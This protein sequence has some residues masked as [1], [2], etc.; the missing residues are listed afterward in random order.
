MK[1]FFLTGIGTD[2]GK[3]ITAAILAQ[4]LKAEYWKPVQAGS[5]EFTDTMRVKSLVSEPDC[6]FHNEVY[7]LQ[8][9][10][11]PHAAAELEGIDIELSDFKPLHNHKTIIIEGAGGL[12]VPINYR[13]LIIDLIPMI[14][15]EVILVSRNYL[16]SINH[17]L[18]SA[19][20]LKQREIPVRGIIFNGA[21]NYYTEKVILDQTGYKPL[22]HIPELEDISRVSV[23][24]IAA[25]ID[26]ELFK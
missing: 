6:I 19:F 21:P 17:T 25:T 1:R 10:M 23:A 11:S 15:D 18:L 5:L 12:L 26:V 9:P 8:Q 22:A 2:V 14:A 4:A 7:R 24:Q 16:G 20:A 3:T 13:E